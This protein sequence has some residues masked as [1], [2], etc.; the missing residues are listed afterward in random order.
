MDTNNYEVA[1]ADLELKATNV[2]EAGSGGAGQSSSLVAVGG[3][4]GMAEG[5]CH[6][7]GAGDPGA[8]RGRYGA[9]RGAEGRTAPVGPG[10]YGGSANW[11][12]HT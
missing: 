1:L 11:D 6:G 7:G 3:D 8:A 12:P 5:G 2:V 4:H 10:V 9:V